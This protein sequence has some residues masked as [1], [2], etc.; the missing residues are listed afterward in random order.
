MVMRTNLLMADTQATWANALEA[1]AKGEFEQA[2]RN[3]RQVLAVVSNHAGA[4]SLL[5]SIAALQERPLEAIARYKEALVYSVQKESIVLR[6]AICQFELGLRQEASST[7]QMLPEQASDA[8]V[9]EQSLFQVLGVMAHGLIKAGF[10][11][12]PKRLL[13]HLIAHDPK[14]FE[15]WGLM[16]FCALEEQHWSEAV[17]LLERAHALN[18]THCVTGLQLV[19]SHLGLGHTQQAKEVLLRLV[20]LPEVPVQA[21]GVLSEMAQGEGDQGEGVRWLEKARLRFPDNDDLLRKLIACYLECGLLDDA[22]ECIRDGVTQVSDPVWIKSLECEHLVA[23]GKLE[24]AIALADTLARDH[25]EHVAP[26]L[27]QARL[28]TVA[29]EFE[30]A[31]SAI[32][33]IKHNHSESHGT[34]WYAAQINWH[35]AQFEFTK[36]QQLLSEAPDQDG[37]PILNL[38]LRL[39]VQ[40]GAVSEA[41]KFSRCIDM[42]LH[43]QG[44][45]YARRSFRHSFTQ[46]FLQEF[47]SNQFAVDNIERIANEP[48]ERQPALIG[49]ALRDEP[50]YMGYPVAMLTRLRQLGT[51]TNSIPHPRMMPIPAR[52]VQFWDRAPIPDDLQALMHTWIECNP[53]MKYECFDDLRAQSFIETHHD[54]RTLVAFR[55]CNVPALRADL[56]RLAYLYTRGGIY[57]DSDDQCKRSL[58]PL[59]HEGYSF[60]G[61][62]EMWGTVG[63]NFMAVAPSHPVLKRALQLVTA[64]IL[65]HQGDNVW[66]VSGPGMLTKAF[67]DVYLRQLEHALMPEGVKLLLPHEISPYVA[68]HLPRRYKADSRHWLSTKNAMRSIFRDPR[69]FQ[70]DRQAALFALGQVHDASRSRGDHT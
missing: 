64:W 43:M 5:G 33:R 32:D 48:L 67:C 20:V 21:F 28:L 59:L 63:N 51:L 39:A 61:L 22:I 52:I 46:G 1:Y 55:S 15:A 4:L 9:I 37:L 53:T 54:A 8:V 50:G 70:D 35:A 66:F 31:Q 34:H 65:G 36:A 12:G 16:G 30:R 11:E 13:V 62:Q 41:R 17:R 29:G 49:Q 10:L 69:P 58:E 38:Q 44:K 45:V 25:P 57:A 24:Q 23:Q 60:I 3:A 56:F 18:P 2:S 7:L 27:E 68:Q 47:G 40:Q 6:L 26:L 42:Q 19:R 14:R